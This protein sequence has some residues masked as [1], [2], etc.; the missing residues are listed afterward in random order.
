MVGIIKYVVVLVKKNVMR[1]TKSM[2]MGP[3]YFESKELFLVLAAVI[4]FIG[5]FVGWNP[6]WFDLDKLLTLILL[7]LIVKG[8]VP[9]VHNHVFFIVSI[10]A[11]LLTLYFSL[12]QV[13]LFY[14]L[15]FAFLKIFKVI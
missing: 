9:T 8:L 5:R 10:A 4:L 2:F 11:L 3:F 12:V 7:I 1:Y 13:L 14:L 15:T 6:V